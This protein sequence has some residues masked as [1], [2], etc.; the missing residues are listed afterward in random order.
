MD[1]WPSC[2]VNLGTVPVNDD[3]IRNVSDKLSLIYNSHFETLTFVN[4][5]FFYKFSLYCYFNEFKI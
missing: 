4:L 3:C 1:M 2:P 5:L